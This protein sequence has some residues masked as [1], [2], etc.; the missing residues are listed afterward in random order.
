ML[1]SQNA[2]SDSI[3]RCCGNNKLATYPVMLLSSIKSQHLLC[4][5]SCGEGQDCGGHSGCRGCDPGACHAACWHPCPLLLV[6]AHV[7]HLPA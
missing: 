5:H 1:A 3:L 2:F 6:G 7:H 4:R